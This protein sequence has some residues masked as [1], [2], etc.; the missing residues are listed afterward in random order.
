MLYGP[1]VSTA[2]LLVLPADASSAGGGG[3]RASGGRMLCA[4]GAWGGG[5]VAVAAGAAAPAEA[6]PVVV[7]VDGSNV[8]RLGSPSPA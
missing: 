6:D 2:Q 7:R 1:Y 8:A 3:R 4:G 5:A